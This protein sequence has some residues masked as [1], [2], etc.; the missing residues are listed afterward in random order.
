MK[1]LI[2]GI[3]GQDGYFLTKFLLSKEYEVYGMYRR[4]ANPHFENISEFF[5]NEHFHLVEGDMTDQ[6]SLY[7]LIQNIG[8][9]EVYNLAAQSFVAVSWKEPI[10]TAQINALGPAM[11]LNSIKNINP[12]IKFYQASTSELYGKVQAVP[13]TELTPFYP[14]SP[15]SVAKLYAY[16]ITVNYRESYNMFACNGILFNHESEIRGPEFVTR[17]ISLG[18]A[19][20][21]K[22]KQEY[23]ALGN[24][25]SKRDWGYAGDYVKAMWLML[26]QD[27]PEDFVIATGET[28]TVREFAEK[29]F[30]AA[31]I[32][33]IWQGEGV[34]EVGI[35]AANNKVVVKVDPQFYRPAETEL[36]LG[37]SKKAYTILGWKPEVTFSELVNKMVEHDLKE[38]E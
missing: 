15:Y 2:T 4:T 24:L 1:A 29:A 36:L 22:N 12:K 11:I 5:N 7:S 38:V 28:H 19:N 31:G 14:R 17:K 18:V 32:D 8:P 16:W 34:D 26:Q 30:K 3:T 10:A 20:I 25:N 6:S 21:V 37:C 27:N 33:I 35:N 23:I 9:D 13:Q